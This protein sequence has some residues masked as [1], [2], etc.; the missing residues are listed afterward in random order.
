MMINYHKIKLLF[1]Y[2]ENL[3]FVNSTRENKNQF[4]IMVFFK[5]KSD[6]IF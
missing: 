6:F 2:D 4:F 1:I 5:C 3:W